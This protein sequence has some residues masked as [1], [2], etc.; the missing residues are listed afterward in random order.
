MIPSR[1]EQRLPTFSIVMPT[2]NGRDFV[3]QAIRSIENQLYPGLDVLVMDACSID[4]TVEFLRNIPGITVVSE[5][6]DGAHDALNKGISRVKGEI[7]GFLAV[8]DLYPDGALLA[9]GQTFAAN[10]DTDLVVGH[11]IVFREGRSGSR[12]PVVKRTHLNGGGMWIPELTFGVPGIF[13]C[14]FRRRVFEQIGGFDNSYRFSGD[15]HLLLRAALQKV[16]SIHL[17][18]PTIYYRMHP[19][20]QTINPE[21][22][23][24]L[25]M[26]EEYVR[27]S[28]ELCS[29]SYTDK[30]NRTILKNWHAFEACKLAV[31]QMMRGDLREAFVGL[32]DLWS[33][34]L[35]WPANL[36][37]GLC[38]NRR[39]RKL[40]E[41]P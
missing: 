34:D 13:G 31:R 28:M 18:R 16:R 40:D 19:G 23:N 37:R 36:V 21:M 41:M 11:S 6:D 8:D 27:M 22:R 38:W 29:A 9:V 24:L 14:F 17:D 35:A 12:N 15:R 7:V 25:A 5:A 20:S 4:G 3:E 32:L 30:A 26:S 39:I 1:D 2:R 33:T 10:E